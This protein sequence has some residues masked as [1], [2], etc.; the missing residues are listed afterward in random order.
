[1]PA[2]DAFCNEVNKRFKRLADNAW[3][4]NWDERLWINPPFHFLGELVQKIKEDRTQAILAVPLW[5][6]KPWWKDALAMTVDSIRLPHDVTLYARDDTDPLQQRLWPTVAFLVNEG[7]ISDGSCTS[8]HGSESGLYDGTESDSKFSDFLG[9]DDTVPNL[10]S[11]TSDGS[12][13]QCDQIQQASPTW[14]EEKDSEKRSNSD[15]FMKNP[16]WKAFLTLFVC[17]EVQNAQGHQA[18][19]TYPEDG[20]DLSLFWAIE[21][22]LL[23]AGLRDLAKICSTMV[24]GEQV[25]S[26]LCNGRRENSFAE[27][28][29]T[30]LPGNPVKSPPVHGP[31]GEAFIELNEGAKPRKQR[32]YENHGKRHEIF[33][34]IIQRNLREFGWLEACMISEWC[35]APSTVPTP[36]AADQKSINCGRMVVNFHN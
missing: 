16:S 1:M 23:P 24:A 7:L 27:R 19:T 10:N 17:E 34:D 13:T 20:V 5:D 29:D 14:P 9:S 26:Q 11:G 31:H 36:P 35:C 3:A 32:P 12:E 2:E 28:N 4:V 15:N 22:G 18:S 25:E 6:W 8:D 21:Q 30:I 33:R